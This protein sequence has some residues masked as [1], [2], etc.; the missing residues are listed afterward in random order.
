MGDVGFA[1]FALLTA[2]GFSAEFCGGANALDLIGM[3][4]S[5]GR[6]Q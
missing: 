6:A 3:Q 4:V 2:M 1:G 5:A